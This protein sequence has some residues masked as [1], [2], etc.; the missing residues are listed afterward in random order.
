MFWKNN[1]QAFEQIF[2]DHMTNTVRAAEELQKL[3]NDLSN[4]ETHIQKIIELEHQGDRLVAQAHELLDGTFITRLDKP[5]IILLIDQMDH[6]VD[7][8]KATASR[9]G[10][11]RMQTTQPGALKTVEI[12]I[13]M[14]RLLEQV[15]GNI[16][17]LDPAD[18]KQKV[19]ALKALEEEAD[20]E[21]ARDLESL[22]ATENDMK[23]VVIW[24]DILQM[25]EKTTDLC[26]SVINTVNSIVRKE[27]R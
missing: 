5:D 19:L 1:D 15:F 24:K 17:K 18:V 7:V 8:I 2:K 20:L 22:F 23:S 11:Y 12:I 4:R 13:R 9:I 21:F 16:P 25:L 14:T 26:K 6:V 3:F 10:I 27:A